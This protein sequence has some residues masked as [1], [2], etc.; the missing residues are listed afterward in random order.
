MHE[1]DLQAVSGNRELKY[2]NVLVKSC[3]LLHD[4]FLF[5]RPHEH[6]GESVILDRPE[7]CD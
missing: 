3:Y 7:L 2:E 5:E 6:L 4:A 1:S